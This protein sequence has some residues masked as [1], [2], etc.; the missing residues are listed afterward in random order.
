MIVTSEYK[1]IGSKSAVT[2]FA[3]DPINWENQPAASF[4]FP[5]EAHMQPASNDTIIQP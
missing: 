2:F 1:K 5:V 3:N 4:D